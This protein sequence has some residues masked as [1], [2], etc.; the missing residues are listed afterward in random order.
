MD[1]LQ[2]LILFLPLYKHQFYIHMAFL[3]TTGILHDS[4]AFA[5][6]CNNIDFLH[7]PSTHITIGC[8]IFV[9]VTS[10]FPHYPTL[11][12]LRLHLFFLATVSTDSTATSCSY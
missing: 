11:Y 8:Q 6:I 9:D 3:P 4:E 7:I 5:M 2:R 12:F 10:G 1:L